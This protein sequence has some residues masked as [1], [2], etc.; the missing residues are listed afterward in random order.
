MWGDPERAASLQEHDYLATLLYQICSPAHIPWGDQR[1]QELLHGYDVWVHM[2]ND[3]SNELMQRA[4]HNMAKHAEMSSNLAALCLHVTRMLRDLVKDIVVPN[5]ESDDD[6]HVATLASP[7][8]EE[9]TRKQNAVTDFSKRIS[10]VAKGRATAGALVLLQW[11]SHEVIVVQTTNTVSSSNDTLDDIF[12]YHTRGDLA[13][14]QPSA[15]PLIHS[16]LDLLT[17]VGNN[18]SALQTPEVYDAVVFALHLLLVLCGTQ[19]YQ[20]FQSSFENTTAASSVYWI[21][22]E[23][24]CCDDE[25]ETDDNNN[26]SSLWMSSRSSMSGGSSGKH[27]TKS[28]RSP[29]KR[30][31]WTPQSILQVCLE[32]QI[33]RPP[34]PEQSLSHYYFILAQAAVSQ[35][36]G[37]KTGQDG[38]YESHMVVQATA[39][40][41]N[42]SGIANGED[43]ANEISGTGDGSG[44]HSAAITPRRHS[45]SHNIILDATRGVLTLGGKII[46]LP[47]RLVSLVVGVLVASK[48]GSHHQLKQSEMM[49]KIASTTKSSRTRDVLWL[50]DSILSDLSCSLILLLANNKRNEKKVG[51]PFR[52]NLSGLTDNRWDEHG[53]QSALPDLPNIT[54]NPTDSLDDGHESFRLEDLTQQNNSNN[55]RGGSAESTVSYATHPLTLNFESL[56]LAFGRTLHTEPGALLLYT[57]LQSSPL[58]AESLAVRSDLDMLVMPLL[59][60]LYFASRSQTYMAKDYASK[61]NSVA[62]TTSQSGSTGRTML[63]IRSCPFRSLSQLYVIII[64]L[65]LFSQDSSFGRDAFK[66]TTVPSVVWYKERHLKNINLGSIL[67]LTVLRLLLFN[68]N[69]LHD[70]FLLSNCCAVLMNV[71]P[72]VVALH[73]YASMRL[74]SVAVTVMKKHAKLAASASPVD[75]RANELEEED[76]NSPLAMHEEVAHTILAVIKQSVSAVNLGE[77]LHLIYALVYHQMDL[78]KLCRNKSLYS[79]KETERIA[80]V[81]LKAASLIQEEG[82]RTAPK[83]LKVL[84]NQID[85]LVKAANGADARTQ[86]KRRK[87]SSGDTS[88]EDDDFTFTYEEEADPEIFFVPYVWELIV[89]CITSTSISWRKDKIR[90]FAILEEVEEVHET[91]GND[92]EGVPTTSGFANADEMV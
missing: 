18:P 31:L 37:E 21:L 47:F 87:Q 55:R 62:S 79:S 51:N 56:F 35:H 5:K 58:F 17:A 13:T 34:A 84:E 23:L 4:C 54:L 10:R 52:S 15:A 22:D 16:I 49:K 78:I 65:L 88:R 60:T 53:G 8:N 71:S 33:H 83:A 74:A 77:N 80:S 67:L 26:L 40:K 42:S 85:S 32:W 25:S 11:L 36:G 28:K 46:L 92:Y 86:S 90:A 24:F 30:K 61:R 44:K 20:P 45:E 91:H 38:M 12:T 39:P 57:L 6:D 29:G 41:R 59:R 69:R 27:K 63:D 48:K 19:L 66:R 7:T 2:D 75:K 81:T 73:E 64:L 68:L 1:W 43:S 82:A 9:S 70:V 3:D 76:L 50:S 72:S 89:C 14:D